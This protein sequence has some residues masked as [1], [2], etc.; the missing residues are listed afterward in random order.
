MKVLVSSVLVSM[1]ALAGCID[2]DDDPQ[3]GDLEQDV[4]SSGLSFYHC[5]ANSACELWLPNTS[6]MMCFLAGITGDLAD[7]SSSPAGAYLEQGFGGGWVLRIKNP[8]NNAIGALTQCVQQT[9]AITKATWLTSTGTTKV[10]NGLT[11]TSRCFLSGVRNYNGSAFSNF[12]SNM[13]VYRTSPTQQTIIGS[14]PGAVSAQFDVVCGSVPTN[15]GDWAY[16]NGTASTVSGNLASNSLGGVA[17]GLTG[18]G[19]KF[20]TRN[21]SDGV[22]IAYSTT[23]PQWG[24]YLSPWKGGYVECVR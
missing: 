4:A 7:G 22:Y 3:L 5:D 8:N 24:W 15:M 10:V 11:A 21:A 14:F 19:G 20:T 13:R 1:F 6:S 16:G 9:G 12:E 18:L 23:S 17:C 2:V